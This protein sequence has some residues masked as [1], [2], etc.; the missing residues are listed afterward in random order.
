VVPPHQRDPAALLGEA[1]ALDVTITLGRDIWLRQDANPRM[2]VQFTGDLRIRKAPEEPG[3][4]QGRLEAI[5]GRSSLE[6]FRRRF[7]VEAGSLLFQGPLADTELDVTSAYRI[8]A[9]Q[10]EDTDVTIRMALAGKFGDLELALSSEPDMEAAD[11]VSY[12]ATGQ[13]ASRA[14]SS[15]QGAEAAAAIGAE[16]VV[17][18]VSLLA[19]RYAT[20]AGLDVLEIRQEGLRGAS[21]VAGKYVTPRLFLGVRQPVSFKGAEVGQ[22]STEGQVEWRALDWLL[23]NLQA[24]GVAF[25]FMLVGSRGY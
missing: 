14:F 6:Q 25:R 22:F 3:N 16:V 19:E 13:P 24:S 7:D 23:A 4:F 18:E 20:Q 9:P 11:M 15:Q 17:S 21:F 10:G 12:L 8:L 5:P 2:A 1:T